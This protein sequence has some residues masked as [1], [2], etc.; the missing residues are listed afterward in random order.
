MNRSPSPS[1]LQQIGRNRRLTVALWCVAAVLALLLFAPPLHAQQIIV[2][3]MV[4]TDAPVELSWSDSDG[5]DVSFA[6]GNQRYA[7]ADV[8]AVTTSRPALARFGPFHVVDGRTV[9]MIGTV[10]SDT[11]AAFAALLRAHPGLARLVMVECPGSVD[12]AANLTLARAVRRAGLSTHVPANGSVRSGAVELWLAGATRT[13]AEGAE[14]GVH[15]WRDED[16]REARDYA[17]SDP[18]HAEYLG[19]YREMGLDDGAAQR[20]Y[21]LTNSVGFDDMRV[22]SVRDMAQLGLVD[23]G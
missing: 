8:S 22:L 1:L 18:V 12:E 9:E 10:D 3:E 13:A 17:T 7:A 20:F 4:E 19:F 11:P 14:F 5:D 6:D 16:G 23:A 15:S 2:E 21:A